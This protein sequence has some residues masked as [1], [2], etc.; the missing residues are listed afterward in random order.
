MRI[1]RR[2]PW[3]LVVG[4]ALVATVVT[5][6]CVS[7]VYVPHDPNRM[8]IDQRLAPP[9]L[10]HPLGTD[11]FG[12]DLLSRILVG[13]QTTL[14]VGVL[15]VSIGMAAGLA[16]GAAAGLGGRWA[17]EALMRLTD[18]LAA[19]PPLLL[20]LMLVAVMG[21]GVTSAMVAIGVATVPAFARLTRAGLLTLRE[22]GMAEAA[23]AAGAG[24][25][26]L[27]TRHLLP[28]LLP[29]LLVEAS[30][31]FANAVLAEAAL[32]YLG[33]GTQPPWP[34]WG[35]MLREGQSFIALSPYPALMPGLAVALT[36][37]GLNLLGDGLRDRM[38]PR[39]G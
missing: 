27:F 33:L 11:P 5:A 37:L 21:A 30:L 18:A 26:R 17:D 2:R 7:L 6:A 24:G 28:N 9:S 25:W 39:R 32:S 31:S 1:G 4:A 20:A 35:R 22:S 23:R 16:L 12:R 38:N 3:N 15:A 19:F 14:W 10:A 34:S 29:V 8:A 36:V 13:A